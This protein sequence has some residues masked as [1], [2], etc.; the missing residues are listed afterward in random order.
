[1]FWQ[2]LVGAW[3]IDAG[4]LRA[5]MEKATREAKVETSWIDRAPEYEHAL[6]EFVEGV[7]GDETFGRELE[8]FV[9]PLLA[10]ARTVALA[11]TLLKLT[12]PGVPDLYQGT[13]LWDL[14]LVD[15]D[16][17]RP[18]DF[19]VR[20][21]LLASVREAAPEDV[22]AQDADGRPKLWLIERALRVR[23]E[24]PEPFAGDYEPLRIT[25]ERAGHG[26]GFL[27]GGRL[28]TVVPRLV[29]GLSG[30]WR[31]TR[32]ALPAGRWQNVLTGDAVDGGSARLAE[33]LAR[34]PVALLRRES[35]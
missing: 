24:H 10:A 26:V 20:R 16:N 3:P 35:A 9:T 4:R 34:F 32:V 19:A 8:A 14:S 15:P 21:A 18:V 11:Q 23:R 12:A 2:T 7:V 17:R 13:E 22:L 5:Y 25:G 28:A 33:V 31:D 29:H 6:R 30:G 1:L 27:R